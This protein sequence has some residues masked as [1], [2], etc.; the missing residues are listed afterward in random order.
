M[1]NATGKAGRST[2]IRHHI[3]APRAIV[4]R[5]LLDAHAVATWMVPTGMTS[6][7]HSFDAREGGSF[8]ISL[9]YDTPTGTGKTTAQTDTFHGR[10]VKLVPNAQVVEV[11]EFETPDP[12]LSGEM[13]ISYTLS[14]ANGG[15]DILPCTIGSRVACLPLTTKSVGGCHWRNSRRSLSRAH[16]LPA[17]AS[18][19]DSPR[20]AVN[21]SSSAL[22]SKTLR[23]PGNPR[24]F[25][26]PNRYTRP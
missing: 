18:A 5:A 14:D 26:P 23:K 20:V 19:R 8:R 15:T 3:N 9:T 12:T 4:Y 21:S 6:T 17:R 25:V 1:E 13:T 7:V 22:G 10:F 24:V 16:D 11:V 2:I